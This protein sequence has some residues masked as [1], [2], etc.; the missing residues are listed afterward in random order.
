MGAGGQAVDLRPERPVPGVTLTIAMGQRRRSAP[1]VVVQLDDDLKFAGCRAT[2]R[3]L[4]AGQPERLRVGRMQA[5]GAVT[6]NLAPGRIAVD[7]VGVV[8]TSFARHQDEGMARPRRR[9]RAQRAHLVEHFGNRQ[10]D[11]PVRVTDQRPCVV[12]GVDTHQRPGAPFEDGAEKRSAQ[13]QA[14]AR[15]SGAANGGGVTFGVA[16]GQPEQRSRRRSTAGQRLSQGPIHDRRG[17]RLPARLAAQRGGQCAE[18]RGMSG[19]AGLESGNPLEQREARRDLAHL[20]QQPR[21]DFRFGQAFAERGEQG[22]A[23]MKGIFGEFQIESGGL[24]FLELGS[25][26]QN[27]MGQT[28]GFAHR[29]ID[30]HQQF[31]LAERSLVGLGI[32]RRQHRVGAVHEHRPHPVLAC[33]L[34]LVGQ[35]V[36]RIETGDREHPVPR[37]PRVFRIALV[38]VADQRKQEGVEVVAATLAEVSSDQVEQLFEI[39]VEGGMERVLDAQIDADA[40]GAGRREAAGHAFDVCRRQFRP[41]HVFGN[42]NGQQLS[43][44]FVKTGAM[45]RE[46]FAVVQPLADDD[47][48][49]GQ[50]QEGISTGLDWQMDVRLPGGFGTARIDHDH[51]ARGILLQVAQGIAGVG[52]A[53]RLIRIGADEQH[54]VGVFDVLGGVAGLATEE[55]AI[56]PEIAGLFLRQRRIDEAALHRLVQLLAVHAAEMVA[57]AATA[58]EGESRSAMPLADRRQAPGDVG[59]R[60][61]P[62]DADE[63]AAGLAF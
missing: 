34:D 31:E 62:A 59:Q 3:L 11:A 53:M 29:H 20:L 41:P 49:H 48:Q 4:A 15:M 36:G 50:H 54:V 21:V 32:R 13:R 14:V 42:G 12:E 28:S 39:A 6:V 51:G 57:L 30:H 47:A 1:H 22:M 60:L 24:P 35:D 27:I 52:N 9:F 58:I 26:R 18:E 37:R 10:V 7:L 38:A 61:V 8:G 17:I 45:P 19:E 63:A 23:E 16:H 44:H 33:V 55:A 56:D 2:F 40:G 5:Q 43:F 25:R 46:K